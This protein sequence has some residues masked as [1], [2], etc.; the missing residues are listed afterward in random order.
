MNRRP[1]QHGRHHHP[2][3]ANDDDDPDDDDDDGHD[4][5]DDCHWIATFIAIVTLHQST[6]NV[7]L[8][9]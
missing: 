6:C 3:Y 2:N 7:L 9:R 8:A 5:D 1:S 4:G